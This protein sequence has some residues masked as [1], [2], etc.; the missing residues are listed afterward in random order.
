MTTAP[1]IAATAPNA[2]PRTGEP[3]STASADTAAGALTG[4]RRAVALRRRPRQASLATVG[5]RG[6]AVRLGV[7]VGAAGSVGHG[8]HRSRPSVRVGRRRGAAP[9]RALDSG[10]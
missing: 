9:E 6:G 4:S 2:I 1:A 5:R 3:R 8:T 7:V 10:P